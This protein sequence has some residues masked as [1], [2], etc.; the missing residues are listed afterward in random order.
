MHELSLA[1]EVVQILEAHEADLSHIT[2]IS[3]DIGTLSCVDAQALRTAL[4]T[5]LQGTLA[6]GAELVM[7]AIE[8]QARCNACGAT[9]APPTRIDPCP[10]CGSSRKTWLA[11]QALQ[12]RSIE[13][14][15]RSA[16]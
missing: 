3:L 14:V 13:G 5:A 15:P 7:N 10:Q 16:S 9:F 8:A 2:R 12:V 11:G 4:D 6:E 1:M